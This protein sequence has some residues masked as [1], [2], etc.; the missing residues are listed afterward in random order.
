MALLDNQYYGEL[1]PPGRRILVF[2]PTHLPDDDNPID[3]SLRAKARFTTAIDAVRQW[4]AER[5]RSNVLLAVVGGWPLYCR[6]PLALHRS[7]AAAEINKIMSLDEI[8]LIMGYGVNTV[9]GFCPTMEWVKENISDINEALVCTSSGHARRLVYE[10]GMHSYFKS[11]SYLESGES[12]AEDEDQRWSQR[13]REIPAHQ[14]LVTGRGADI[15]RFGA[16]DALVW[17]ENMNHWAS[18]HQQEAE[19]YLAEI[20]RFIGR[21]EQENIVIRFA[22]NAWRLALN[23]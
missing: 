11:I 5:R 16:R 10:S 14:Y 7:F 9:T 15:S 4:R 1:I 2:I 8:D 21:C 22:S 13:A 19:D 17:E 20:W 12:R 18:E 3:I 23:C 6:L